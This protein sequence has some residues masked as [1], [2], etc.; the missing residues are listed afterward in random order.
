MTE[1]LLSLKPQWW[2]KIASGEKTVEI[3]K[4]IPHNGSP[5]KVI[6][7]E[8]KEGRGKVIGEFVCD[9]I[10][11]YSTGNIGDQTISSEEIQ[12]RSCLTYDELFKY[13]NSAESKENCIYLMGL[14]GWHISALQIYDK[15]INISDFGLKRAPQSWQYLKAGDT[16]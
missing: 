8:T 3:R 12:K 7:Y 16:P 10:Y 13:E 2:A 14:Y 5:F 11:Q 1:I 4:T 6:V 9:Q 15:P